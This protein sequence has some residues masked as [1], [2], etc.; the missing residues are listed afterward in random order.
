[1]N[2]LTR[3]S[4]LYYDLSLR[5]YSESVEAEKIYA[6]NWVVYTGFHDLVS[7]AMLYAYVTMGYTWT[8]VYFLFMKGLNT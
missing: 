3:Y 7:C 1:M 6:F 5:C 2:A 8:Q 4:I